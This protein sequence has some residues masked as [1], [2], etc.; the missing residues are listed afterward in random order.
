MSTLRMITKKCSQ[1]ENDH[2]KSATNN[3]RSLPSKASK[4]QFN[5]NYVEAVKSTLKHNNNNVTK[6]VG[7]HDLYLYFTEEGLPRFGRPVLSSQANSTDDDLHSTEKPM[8]TIESNYHSPPNRIPVLTIYRNENKNQTKT[9][10][11]KANNQPQNLNKNKK[12]FDYYDSVQNKHLKIN[13]YDSETPHLSHTG[14]EEPVFESVV[15]RRTIG[16]YIGN[17]GLVQTEQGYCNS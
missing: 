10:Q 15:R 5:G 1:S 8:Q 7:N 4:S 3:F 6:S 11:K 13:T 14:C 17:I 9:N 16:Y 2:D 12:I